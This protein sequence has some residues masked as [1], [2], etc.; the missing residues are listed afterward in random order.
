MDKFFKEIS[1]FK[2]LFNCR[3]DLSNFQLEVTTLQ[4]NDIPR[5]KYLKKDLKDL[6]KWLLS[7]KY[8]QLLYACGLISIPDSTYVKIFSKI[9][10]IKSHFFLSLTYKSL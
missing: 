1:I 5:G 10:Y 4:C 8:I 6:H 3:I 9:N 2:K 7:N